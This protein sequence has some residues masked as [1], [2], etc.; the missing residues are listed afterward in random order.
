MIYLVYDCD[1]STT[2]YRTAVTIVFFVVE[3]VVIVIYIGN[4]DIVLL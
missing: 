3:Y 2:H 1:G 4:K